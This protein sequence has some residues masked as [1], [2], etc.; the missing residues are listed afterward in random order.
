MLIRSNLLCVIQSQPNLIFDI[1]FFSTFFFFLTEGMTRGN[2]MRVRNV[3]TTNGI[4]ALLLLPARMSTWIKSQTGSNIIRKRNLV[5][6]TSHHVVQ[7]Q[8]KLMPFHRSGITIVFGWKKWT[9]S[10]PWSCVWINSMHPDLV[11]SFPTVIDPTV[12]TLYLMLSV[13]QDKLSLFRWCLMRFLIIYSPHQHLTSQSN[14]VYSK[15]AKEEWARQ[16]AFK[17]S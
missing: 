9:R 13:H 15:W 5:E 8:I 11:S 2:H 4:W 16:I 17:R 7:L 14:R 3:S 10:K 12:V 1:C 6:F